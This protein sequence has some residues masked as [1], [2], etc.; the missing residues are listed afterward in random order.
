MNTKSGS[1]KIPS[2]AK[3]AAA[4]FAFSLFG[5]GSYVRLTTQENSFIIF[6]ILVDSFIVGLMAGLA[7]F[8]L[9]NITL[10]NVR[11]PKKAKPY[12]LLQYIWDTV[13][14][15]FPHPETLGLFPIGQP[16]NLSPIIATGNFRLTVK[17]V[18]NAINF[19]CWLLICNSRGINIWC[20]SLAGHFGA[21]DLIKAIENTNLKNM[22]VSRRII[23]P[24]LCAANV[25]CDEICNRTGFRAEF[26]P[27]YARNL[28]TYMEQP[29]AKGIRDVEF[30]TI[31]RVEMAIGSP[32]IISTVLF[33]IYNFFDLAPL[34][35][36]IP[37]L[38]LLSVIHGLFYPVRFI[39]NTNLWAL[40]CGLVVFTTCNCFLPFGSALTTGVGM[41]YLVTEFEGWS[42]LVKYT[43]G[44]K[45][46]V[47][48]VDAEKCIGCGICK[49]VC[50]R[51][52]FEISEKAITHRIQ[53]CEMCLSCI[54]Q[55]PE[56]AISKLSD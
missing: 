3:P 14:R 27:V 43:I 5:I 31:Q 40:F 36:I 47:V 42:P 7:G 38:Y 15:L 32:L 2:W 30:N 13:F 11:P 48:S 24:Q 55:C 12:G 44:K 19:D 53:H 10:G 18:K 50:P 1:M 39:K 22:T 20:A 37:L 46:G 45:A 35:Y 4:I 52:V 28:P 17:R 8:H 49:K 34:L 23:L 51:N 9:I 41:A 25:F 16:D 26:G 6:S 29:D 21:T 54:K 33:A 56:Q